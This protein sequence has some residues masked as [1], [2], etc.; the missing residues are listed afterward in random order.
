MK[1]APVKPKIEYL[2]ATLPSG[3]LIRGHGKLRKLRSTAVTS[4]SEEPRPPW[5]AEIEA[6]EVA[7]IKLDEPD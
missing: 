1:S 4:P 3:H 7:A 6:N 2:F 5:A